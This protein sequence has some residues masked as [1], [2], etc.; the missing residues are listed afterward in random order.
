[1]ITYLNNLRAEEGRT[2]DKKETKVNPQDLK[3]QLA[4]DSQWK[5]EKG[6]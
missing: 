4:S 1:M 6:L 5:K 2:E 3:A